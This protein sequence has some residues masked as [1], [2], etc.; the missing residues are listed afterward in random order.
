MRAAIDYVG[1]MEIDL[2][3][4]QLSAIAQDTRLRVF[5]LLIERGAGGL[6]AGDIARTLNV[7]ANTLSAH[8]QVLTNAG[9]T[10]ARRERRNI[11]YSVRLGATRD[12]LS[13]LVEDC[14]GGAPEICGD[15]LQ[16]SKPD[17][18]IA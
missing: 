14:C 6:P 8:L 9:L 15:L 1:A 17:C 3:T 12:L 5:R 18:E 4:R 13:Y 16:A 2:A 10:T 11:I 7:P